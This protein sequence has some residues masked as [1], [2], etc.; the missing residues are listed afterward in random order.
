MHNPL[1][2]WQDELAIIDRTMKA[3]SSITDPE[4]LVDVY[5]RSISELIDVGDYTAL[6]R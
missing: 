4:E 5:W 2:N 3:I 6:S 1:L